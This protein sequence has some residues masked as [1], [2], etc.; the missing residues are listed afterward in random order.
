MVQIRLP[1]GSKCRIIRFALSG[2][3]AW[4]FHPHA[5]SHEEMYKEEQAAVKETWSKPQV[6]EQ[7]V[8]LEVTSYVAAEIK[9]T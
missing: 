9:S 4:G 8:G 7:E 2:V 3:A 5:A 1:A 6:T